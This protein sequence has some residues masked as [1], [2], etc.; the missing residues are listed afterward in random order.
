MALSTILP[1]RI[2]L[3]LA[4]RRLTES[5]T[6]GQTDLNTLQEQI[7][8][9]R[10]IVLPSDAPT[11]ATQTLTLQK[12]TERRTAFQES[13]GTNQGFLGATDQALGTIGDALNHARGL[14]QAGLGDQ[15]SDVER[16]T[17]ADEVDSLL[18]SV[19]Q[20]GNAQYNGR[21]LFAGS[22][23]DQT[24]FT[25]LANGE[26]R[27]AGDA[28]PLDTFANFDLLVNAGVDGAGGLHGVTTPLYT[29]INPALTLPTRLDQL[30]GGQGATPGSVQVLVVDGA[31]EIR[32]TVDLTSAET[33][34]DVKTRIE[35]AFAAESITVTVAID[36]GTNFGLRLT[37]SAG[38]IE[39]RDVELGRTALELGI[40]SGPLAVLSGED[41]DPGL[42]Q[43]T[44]VA[45]LNGNTG[46]GATAGTGL[47]IVNG[48]RV[49]VVDLDG[50]TTIGDVLNRIRAADPDLL[51]EISADGRGL[52]I[53]SRLSGADFSIGENGGTN[54]TGLGIRTFTGSTRLADLNAGTGVPVDDGTTLQITRRDGSQVAVSLAGAATVQDVLNLLNAVDP[55]NLVAGLNTVGNGIS[56]TDNSGAGA[57][58]VADNSLAVALGLDG[59]EN[60]GATG[61]LTGDDVNP[62]RAG[63]PFDLLSGLSRALRDN[64]FVAL[65]RLGSQLEAEAAR[66]TQVR[67]DVGSRQQ[68]LDS[69]D[70]QLSDELVQV[71]EQLSKLFDVDLTEAITA[72]LQQQQSLQATMQVSAQAAQLSILQYL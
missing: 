69:V 59:T 12:L 11:A 42:S 24:P 67:G 7:G 30:N 27:Y 65:S 26:V 41:V 10:K 68:L 61:V 34:A 49:S 20:A 57:L 18:K 51:A 15:S 19:L 64:D 55:G 45:S 17:L 66:I 29:D 52:A 31:T 58:T 43:F 25:L 9:G 6:R 22:E 28:R 33:L 71:K 16:Q 62:Q 3:S 21:Y 40:R 48:T 46:I 32:K 1:G 13:I 8:S 35:A 38:T 23:T 50:A 72:F 63:G 70:N 53:S 36:P 47:R 56:L 37:P 60:T 44:T 4:S 14:L 39:V 54:A 5:I 2:P